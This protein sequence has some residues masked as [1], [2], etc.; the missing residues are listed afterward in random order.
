MLDGSISLNFSLETRLK[1]NSWAFDR[2]STFL[3][4]KLWP[5]K[6]KIGNFTRNWYFTELANFTLSLELEMLESRSKA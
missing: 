2:L 6:H 1:S 3:V 4:Q 5:K